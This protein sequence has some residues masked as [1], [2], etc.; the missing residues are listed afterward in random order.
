MRTRAAFTMIE[1]IFVIVVMGIIGKFGVE[2]LAQAYKS[3]IFSNV[4]NAL[5]S[6][7]ASA[8]EF[9]ASRLQY[10]IK[11]SVIARDLAV[12]E[13]RAIGSA[14]GEAFTVLEWIGSDIDGFRGTTTPNW[15]GI[16][17]L[18]AGNNALF[19]SPETNTTAV[20]ALISTLSYSNSTINDAALYFIGSNSDY[21]R[22]AWDNNGTALTAHSTALIHPINS[23]ANPDEFVT[24]IGGVD[25]SGF[26]IY[27]YYKLAWTAYAIVYTPGTNNMGTLTLWYDYQPWKGEDYATDGRSAVIME[28]VSAFQFMSIGSIIKIQVCTKTD[29]LK[30]EDEYSLCKEKTIF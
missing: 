23:N 27:E 6:K 1:L 28:D 11:D 25:F 26:D 7:S 21:T 12:P 8:V 2:F 10:R 5:Q 19:N 4:N 20:N 18:D 13:T 17:D 30:S 14:S 29:L 24:G 15:S 9:I 16:I 22:Y 3:F